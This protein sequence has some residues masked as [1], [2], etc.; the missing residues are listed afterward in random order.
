MQV[1]IMTLLTMAAAG[2]ATFLGLGGLFGLGGSASL[3]GGAYGSQAVSTTG[4]GSC[5]AGCVSAAMP[6]LSSGY[7]VGQTS[8]SAFC[9][10]PNLQS[11]FNVHVSPCSTACA[12]S[13]PASSQ[14]SRVYRRSKS[15]FFSSQLLESSD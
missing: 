4:L 12:Q 13:Q 14:P 11:W 10:Q 3:G 15:F 9:S 8:V 6:Q 7:A 2:E 5:Q 1:S